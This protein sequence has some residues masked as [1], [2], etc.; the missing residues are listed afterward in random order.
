MQGPCVGNQ[1]FIANHPCMSTI[2]NILEVSTANFENLQEEEYSIVDEVK[3]KA[4]TM[5]AAL[6][7][8]REDKA[9]E[10]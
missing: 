6:L 2:A 3:N 4:V 1:D 8:G 10:P 7:E 5:V 9:N